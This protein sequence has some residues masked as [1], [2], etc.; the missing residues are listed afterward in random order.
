MRMR[1]KRRK[2]EYGRNE[3]RRDTLERV[4]S[5]SS[6]LAFDSSFSE[7]LVNRDCWPSRAPSHR[8]SPIADRR[9]AAVSHPPSAPPRRNV[10][11]AVCCEFASLLDIW[12]LVSFVTSFDRS[13][14]RLQLSSSLQASGEATKRHAR[15]CS[16][17]RDNIL[18]RPILS[19]PIVLRHTS[20]GLAALLEA[21][22]LTSLPHLHF[23]RCFTRLSV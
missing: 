4:P 18:F 8:R 2:G 14:S 3:Y 6:C 1:S 17:L 10:T 21:L 11:C 13:A 23:Q 12:P 19:Y 7:S 15:I 16:N 20:G 9:S 22:L 5:P